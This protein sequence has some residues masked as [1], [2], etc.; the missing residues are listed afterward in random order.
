MMNAQANVIQFNT[1]EDKNVWGC[2]NTFFTRIGQNSENTKATYERAI[3]DFFLVMRNKELERLVESDLI[4]TKPQVETYQVNLKSQY[5]SATVN[6]R[7]SALKR[8]Y[9]K[10]E[11]YGF[12]VK[13]SWFD[14]ER[15]S[16]HDKESYDSMT[17]DEVKEAINIIKD[18]RKG[19]EKSLF[20]ELAFTTAFRKES[21]RSTVFHDIYKH[22]DSW[23][24]ETIGKGNKKDT[25]KI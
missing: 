12:E 15:Y 8:V 19:T 25:K 2:M 22:G 9:S 7:I 16:E 3:R 4:F 1:N 20:I 11:D 13:S 24:I 10:L 14:L 17:L 23:V 18:T 5:K 21:L 6:N